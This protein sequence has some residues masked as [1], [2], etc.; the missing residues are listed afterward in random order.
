MTGWLLAAVLFASTSAVARRRFGW[1]IEEALF[2][3]ALVALGE[4]VIMALGLAWFDALRPHRII[5]LTAALA[6]GQGLYAL[7]DEVEGRPAARFPRAFIAAALLVGLVLILRLALSWALPFE[8]W[9]GL[10][11]HMPIIWRWLRQGGLEMAGWSGPQR[12]FPPNADLLAAWLALA[13]GG[14]LEGAK[15]AQALALPL[16]GACGAVLGR[17]LAGPAWSPAC[18]LAFLAVPIVVIHAGIPYVDLIHAAFWLAAVVCALLFERTGRSAWLYLWGAAFGLSLGAKATLYFQGPLLVQPFVTVLTRKELRPRIWRA[19]PATVLLALVCGGTSYLRLWLEYGNPV[20]PYTFRLAGHTIFQGVS[21]PGE[22]LV[23][24]ERW[25]VARPIEWLWYPFRETMRG[26]IGYGTENGF[27]SLF[28]AGWVLWPFAAAR[29]LRRQDW[30]AASFYAVL[31]ASALMFFTLH[32]TREPRYV[33]FLAAVPI[34]GAA[35]ALRGLRGRGLLLARAVW[36]LGLGWGLLGVAAYA[37]ADPGLSRAV[38]TLRRTHALDA[39]EYY[40]W[41][42][43][44]LGEAW[45]AL[46]AKLAADDVVATNYGELMLPLAGVPARARIEVI[47]TRES[48]Y[49]ETYAATTPE[50]WLA[51]L[52]SLNVR[53]FALWS[54]AWYKDVGEREREFVTQSPGRFVSLGKWD[55]PGFGVIELFELTAPK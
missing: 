36:T 49:P 11:Y 12:Y 40:H 53:Y 17:R 13:S 54:P 45:K 38:Q 23:T 8:S 34:L 48:D 27:G 14:A 26:A 30:A 7:W 9:D 51:Q 22:L 55:S 4:A 42:F 37:G 15:N 52:E 41:Q 2:A 28:A 18:A 25:F 32:P 50:T 24:V 31:P 21:E 5:G 16:W 29:A 19:L 43:G 33:I 44:S 10:S 47:S 46:D 35:D 39:H 3:G 1:R 20:Y 6:L